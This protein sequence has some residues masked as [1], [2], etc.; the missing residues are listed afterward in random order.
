MTSLSTHVLDAQ[1]GQPA[2]GVRVSL[3][4]GEAVL[5]TTITGTDGRIAELGGASL[6]DGIYRLVFDV[7]DYLAAQG[8][9][10]PFLQRVSVEFRVDQTQPHYHVPLL[11]TPFACTSYRGS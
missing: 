4:R 8:R 9:P 3:L 6:D 11:V 10:A 7:A 1:R 2:A 5:A